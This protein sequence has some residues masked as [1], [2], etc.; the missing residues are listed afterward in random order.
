MKELIERAMNGEINSHFLYSELKKE[1][2]KPHIAEKLVKEVR[3]TVNH[4][5]HWRN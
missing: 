2:V 5:S 1:G 4:G 3:L